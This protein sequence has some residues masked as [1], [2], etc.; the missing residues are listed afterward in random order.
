MQLGELCGGE[1][2]DINLSANN[3]SCS[4]KLI[5]TMTYSDLLHD[6]RVI[7]HGVYAAGSLV[8][9]EGSYNGSMHVTLHKGTMQATCVNY[10]ET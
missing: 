10:C 4:A 9:V 6:F 3:R 7:I 2:R 1:R 5:A 8:P